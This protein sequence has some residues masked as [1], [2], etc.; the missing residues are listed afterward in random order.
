MENKYTTIDGKII[1]QLIEAG[2]AWLAHN[3]QEVNNMNVFPV[4][5]GD[6]GTNMFHTMNR[7]IQEIAEFSSEH[8]GEVMKKVAYGTLMGARGNSGTILSQILD[9]FAKTIQDKS[10]I[11]AEIFHQACQNAV[12]AAYESVPNPIEGT[13]LTVVREAVDGLEQVSSTNLQELL[14][15][16]A[17]SA[18]QSLKHTP[19]LLPV[20]KEAGVVDSGGLGLVLILEGMIR[21]I[22]GEPVIF[23]QEASESTTK[24]QVQ[25]WQTALQPEDEEGYGYDVQFLMRG[26]NFDVAKVRQDIDDMGWSTLVVGD[27]TLIKVHVHVHDPGQPISYAIANGAELDD[28]V[29]E[30]MQAQYHQYVDNRMQREGDDTNISADKVAVITVASGTGI[31]KIFRDLKV[32]KL[33]SGGQTMNPSTEDFI[34]AIEQLPNQEI[35]ILPNNKNI[36]SAAQQAV[37]LSTKKVS[38]IST[39]TILQGISA[40]IEYGSVQEENLSEIT[41]TMQQ[42]I[43]NI[44]SVEI[45]TATKTTT[46]NDVQIVEGQFISIVDGNLLLATDDLVLAIEKTLQQIDLDEYELVT[47]YYGDNVTEQESLSII[48]HL[49][50]I[51][52]ELEF[53]GVNGGQPLYPILISIE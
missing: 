32:A 9:G 31:Q 2:T 53:E 37:A 38:V 21:Y 52:D 45:T 44:I 36:I 15:Q 33:I 18:R 25:D 29:V 47:L 11:D 48:E 39:R 5:D 51:F 26:D 1:H 23:E 43:E 12:T 46:I 10:S 24:P 40:M 42:A 22:N 6:T 30:N 4:P 3:Q 41:P 28:I 34:N 19:E 49:S 35:I 20:L 17:D 50:S 13:I 7:A 27:S 16:L 8:A 14:V